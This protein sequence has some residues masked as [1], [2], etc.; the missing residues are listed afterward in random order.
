[1]I[2]RVQRA[3]GPAV[4]A[5]VIIL[6]VLSSSSA[7]AMWFVERTRNPR[8]AT[9]FS[10]VRWVFLSVFATPPW[11][12][13]TL[14]GEIVTYVVNLL[15]PITVAVITAALT[16]FLFQLVV[17][18][19]SGMGRARV[20]DHI[21]ICGWSGK[22]T[23]IIREIRRRQEEERRR[24]IVVLAPLPVSPAKDELT[25]FINGDPTKAEDLTRA[26]IER[27]RTAIVLADNSYPDIDVEDMDSR[28]LITVLA[29]ESLNPACYTCVEVV[30][31]ESREHFNRTKAD[32][33]VVSAHLTGALLAHSAVTRGLSKVVAD[34]LTHPQGCEFY[35]L[36]VPPALGGKTFH[37]A[38]ATLKRDHECI[39]V[40]LAR[41][42]SGFVTNPPAGERLSSGD[43]LLVISQH[44]PEI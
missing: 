4:I 14:S 28:T 40:A 7:F 6:V 3:L 22:G 36:P 16:S 44:A 43:R 11:E 35:W 20:K 18:R 8:V 13:V 34:L 33:L 39:L 37:E 29:I 10:G 9:I 2:R 38:L 27:A 30:N 41:D 15:K 32:E 26:G 5:A 24:P 1:M 25:T 19:S 23:E 42:S 31:S 21:V 12:P 17:R